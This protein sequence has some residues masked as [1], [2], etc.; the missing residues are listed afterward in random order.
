[1]RVS[2]FFSPLPDYLQGSVFSAS[3]LRDQETQLRETFRLT[4]RHSVSGAI[5][6]EGRRAT[7]LR[8]E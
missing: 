1:M 3:F 4:T 7:D 8:R 2:R 5:A 6:S